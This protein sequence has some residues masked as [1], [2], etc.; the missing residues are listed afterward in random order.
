MPKEDNAKRFGV[1]HVAEILLTLHL[2]Q[3]G[4]VRK[5][6]RG[7]QSKYEVAG[8][9]MDSNSLT[10]ENDIP[11]STTVHNDIRMDLAIE[12]PH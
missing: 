9:H 7:P 6:I 12:T 3:K 4:S 1:L 10:F 5:A 8:S 2:S 11:E